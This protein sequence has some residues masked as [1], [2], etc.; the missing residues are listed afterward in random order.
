[1]R[2]GFHTCDLLTPVPHL[3]WCGAI[4]LLMPEPTLIP[5]LWGLQAP[6]WKWVI[7]L[8]YLPP[9]CTTSMPARTPS[10]RGIE[11]FTVENIQGTG[12]LGSSRKC[13]FIGSSS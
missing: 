12:S 6:P 10:L 2:D 13:V 11:G 3:V 7:P 1:M 4:C 5:P 8:F 9:A